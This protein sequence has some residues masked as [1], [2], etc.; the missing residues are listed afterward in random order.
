MKRRDCVYLLAYAAV[1]CFSTGLLALLARTDRVGEIPYLRS[2]LVKALLIL[3]IVYYVQLS[4]TGA[5]LRHGRL[6]RAELLWLLLPPAAALC[7]Y[8]G[9]PNASPSPLYTVMAILNVCVGAILSELFFRFFGRL[10]FERG[11]KYHLVVLFVMAAVYGLTRL[12][13][14]VYMPIGVG[15]VL[16]LCFC[17]TAQGIFLTALYS[18]TRHIAFPIFAHLGQDLVEVLFRQFTTSPSGFFGRGDLFTGLLTVAYTA[19]GFWLLFFAH[20]IRE[21][22]RGTP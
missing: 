4:H 2:V 19:I 7:I 9:T 3:L 11:G 17:A 10:L 22:A 16:M 6:C 13:R 5:C 15:E 18:R 8:Y 14:A 1:A 20:R 21:R 12:F